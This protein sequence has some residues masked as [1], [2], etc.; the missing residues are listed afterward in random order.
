MKDFMA[1]HERL[2][3]VAVEIMTAGFEVGMYY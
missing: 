1:I 3:S 2:D